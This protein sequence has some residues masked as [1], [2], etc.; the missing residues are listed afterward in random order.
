MR[1]LRVVL[2]IVAACLA[3]VSA[4]AQPPAGGH[5]HPA[6][7]PAPAP[8]P[9]AGHQMPAEPSPPVELPPF[10][11][12]LTDADRAAAFPDVH[13][14]AAHDRAINAFVLF[15]QLEW[16]AGAGANAFSWDTKGW[17]GRD[18][19]RFWFRSEG[20]RSGGRTGQAQTHLLY[21][22]QISRW[23]D[24]TAGLRLDTL[25]DT[26]RGALAIGVQGLAPYW[27][28]VEA[29]AFV[30]PSGRTH[31]RVETEYDLLITNRLVLQP[32]AEFEIYGRADRERL[33]GAGLSMGEVG[34]RLR[35]VI[36]RELAPYVGVVW[37]RRFFGS[38]RLARAAGDET[39]SA[40]LA[41]G[42][43]AWF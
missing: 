14:H 5:Q 32:L 20:D 4:F 16:Q 27:F 18:R 9:H 10:I 17:I 22:R 23:W 13:G 12:P 19:T 24:L 36:R 2:A 34:L 29:S 39:S 43:R 37:N 7:P 26:P 25:P 6:P 42:L 15:D 41:V 28:E 35:Y 11:P 21:G 40:R 30:E 3:P 8:D 1:R 38:A 31:V 33:I